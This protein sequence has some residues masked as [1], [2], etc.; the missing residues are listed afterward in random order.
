MDVTRILSFHILPTLAAIVQEYENGARKHPLYEMYNSKHY[1]C[2]YLGYPCV[3]CIAHGTCMCV[4][5]CILYNPKM[6]ISGLR[7]F[8]WPELFDKLSTYFSSCDSRHVMM[9]VSSY[10]DKQ[11]RLKRQYRKLHKR[12]MKELLLMK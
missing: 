6:H 3:N 12:V 7:L 11:G 2:V 1:T 9:I 4:S 8:S 5:A 10:K